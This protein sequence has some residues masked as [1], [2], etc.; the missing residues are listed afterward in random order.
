MI[1]QGGFESG[2]SGWTRVDQAAG[3]GS[4]PLFER[5]LVRLRARQTD[6]SAAPNHSCSNNANVAGHPNG[7]VMRS[8]ADERLCVFMGDL[9]RR[10]WLCETEN[11]DDAH[12]ELNRVGPGT[13][14][15]QEAVRQG[16]SSVAASAQSGM[17]YHVVHR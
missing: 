9:G 8:G 17:Y 11:A 1:T 13:V 2:H 15:H 3:D 6:N 5:K 12:A 10:G 7:G 16:G 14:G 4:T